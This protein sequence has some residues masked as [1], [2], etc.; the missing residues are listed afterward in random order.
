MASIFVVDDSESTCKII[1]KILELEGHAVRTESNPLKAIEFL[2][3]I[4]DSLSVSAIFL[5]LNMPEMNGH[6]F[7]EK[8][9][10]NPKLEKVPIILLTASEAASSMIK[11]YNIGVDYFM[12]KPT[13]K[14]QL[15]YALHTVL[16]ESKVKIHEL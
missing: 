13:T 2:S 14:K 15:L 11:S 1:K 10:K 8:I 4:E 9:K 12:S 7:V 3:N 5:D 16:E 6:E